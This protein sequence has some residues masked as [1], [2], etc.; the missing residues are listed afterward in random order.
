M[1]K[2]VFAVAV[3]TAALWAAVTLPGWAA[4]G[5]IAPALVEKY[6]AS[7]WKEAA[8]EWRARLEQDETQK[9]CT[10]HANA[11]P[12]DVADAILKR[13]QATMVY[14]ADGN[15]IGDWKN[16]EKLAQSG[17]GGRFTDTDKTRENGGNCYACHQLAAS[18]IA[19]GTLGP[20]LLGYGKARSFASSEAMA[21]Y[22]KIYNSQ[23]VVA[24]SNMPLFGAS[25]FLSPEQIRDIVAFVMSPDSPVNK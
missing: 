23:A 24:C 15:L 2:A 12:S 10:E 16:G 14:P 7:S 11:P 21:V 20:S 17:Y 19:Y 13:E 18:E 9:A 25:K 5:T 1:K 22:E 6:I 4:K 3:A 8:P